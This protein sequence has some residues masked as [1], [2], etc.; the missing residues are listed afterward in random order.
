M[1]CVSLGDVD[2]ISLS[3]SGSQGAAQAECWSKGD[4]SSS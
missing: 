2:T 4:V 3:I 1:I